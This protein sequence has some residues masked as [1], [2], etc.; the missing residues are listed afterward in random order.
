MRNA[1]LIG[2]TAAALIFGAASAYAIP[3]NSPYRGPMTRAAP[4]F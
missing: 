4:I 2:S 1:I 3:P